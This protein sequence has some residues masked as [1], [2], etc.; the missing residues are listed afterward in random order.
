M[1][2]FSTVSILRRESEQ[3][4]VELNDRNKELKSK[5]REIS[6]LQEKRQKDSIELEENRQQVQT[7]SGEITSFRTRHNDSES[8]SKEK[9]R[10]IACLRELPNSSSSP[11]SN[12]S[13]VR[14]LKERLAEN[15]SLLNEAW[16]ESA[17]LRENRAYSE[18]EDLRA[19]SEMGNE[20]LLKADTELVRAALEKEREKFEVENSRR[21]NRMNATVERLE[22]I[23]RGRRQMLIE[24][25]ESKDSELYD[26][27]KRV[28]ELEQQ[29]LASSSLHSPQP[30]SQATPISTYPSPAIFLAPPTAG[31]SPSLGRSC[32]LTPRSLF[33]TFLIFFLACFAPFLHSL[34]NLGSEH[35]LV[36]LTSRVDRLHSEAWELAA[37]ERD[38]GV[39]TYEESWRR[40]QEVGQMG[41]WGP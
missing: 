11:Q 1:T 9:D 30:P 28:R 3:I 8:S 19:S 40:T 13:D 7:Q 27:Q 20:A 23:E 33:I 37:R 34:A 41:D 38:E 2:S 21:E 39:P 16:S 24:E 35:E 6:T 5:T 36:G 10:K 14:L 4:S 15:Q 12:I 18:L 26:A 32:F 17:S 31:P 22:E 29:L 25:L